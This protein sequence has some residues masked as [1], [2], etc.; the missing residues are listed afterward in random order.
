M[1]NGNQVGEFGDEYDDVLECLRVFG[2][3]ASF[4]IGCVSNHKQQE[5]PL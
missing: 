2:H 3:V 1:S 5:S 4:G